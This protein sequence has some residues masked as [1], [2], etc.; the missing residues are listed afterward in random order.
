MLPATEDAFGLVLLCTCHCSSVG[1][2]ELGSGVAEGGRGELAVDVLPAAFGLRPR[3]EAVPL[4]AGAPPRANGVPGT[5]AWIKVRS[6]A[7]YEAKGE[8][9]MN[10]TPS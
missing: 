8:L 6:G 10:M 5:L 1:W 3:L 4:A 9:I 2:L 7:G